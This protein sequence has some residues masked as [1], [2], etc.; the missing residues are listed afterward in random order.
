MSE[1]GGVTSLSMECSAQ[2]GVVV[3]GCEWANAAQG[4][5]LYVRRTLFLNLSNASFV[6]AKPTAS[7]RPP[8]MRQS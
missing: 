2:A 6:P 3:S 5:G 7:V 4:V 8:M 1:R